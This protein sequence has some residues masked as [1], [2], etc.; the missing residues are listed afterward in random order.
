M[1][2]IRVAAPTVTEE[3]NFFAAPPHPHTQ[4]VT[5]IISEKNHREISKYLFQEGVCY[6]KKDYNLAKHPDIDVPNLQ[7]IKLMQSFKSREYVRETFAWMHYYWFLTNDGIEFLRT[8]LN[9]PSEIVPATLKKQAKPVFARPFGGDR[10]RGPPRFEG[11]RR[12]GGDHDG[13]RGGPRG[14]GGE[15]GGEPMTYDP[16]D[17]VS[18]K[19]RILLVLFCLA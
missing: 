13:Y 6:A 17:E 8:Y 14:P 5:M 7:V 18:S 2:Y 19:T 11:Q 1:Q 9:L 16:N 12:F 15:F 10:P 3:V 4:L